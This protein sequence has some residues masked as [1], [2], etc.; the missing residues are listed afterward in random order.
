[1]EAREIM[2]SHPDVLSENMTLKQAAA[3]MLKIDCGFLPIKHNG[4]I[5]GV[6]TDRDLVI[7]ALAKGLNPNEAKLE[8]VMTKEIFYCHEHDDIKKV[9]EMMSQKQIHRVVVFDDKNQPVGVI[10]IGDIARKC[11]DLSL[12][13]KLTEAIH[14]QQRARA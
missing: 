14:R 8:Q 3:E 9:A 7:R 2:S 5:T 12:C 13:G 11:K 10:S 4:Q 6:I 1:M